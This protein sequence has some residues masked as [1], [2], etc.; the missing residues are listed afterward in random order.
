M[1]F[2]CLSLFI[3]F[4]N[5]YSFHCVF[6]NVKDFVLF[7]DSLGQS[8]W[9]RV[10]LINHTTTNIGSYYDQKILLVTSEVHKQIL[11][12]RY[13]NGWYLSRNNKLLHFKASQIV[14]SLH[15]QLVICLTS[16]RIDTTKVL[17]WSFAD[18]SK[19]KPL[20]TKSASAF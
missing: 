7:L 18:L 17:N 6:L 1:I 20:H 11:R 10:F 13:K 12:Y 3:I 14:M 5:Y 19:T 8:L 9:R 2:F 4:V 15:S 16:R